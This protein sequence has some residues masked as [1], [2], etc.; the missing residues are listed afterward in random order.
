MQIELGGLATGDAL[1][2]AAAVLDDHGIDRAAIKRQELVDLLER[3]GGHPLSLNLALP[4]LRDHTL[5]E[6]T[7]RFE[8]LLP[9]FTTGAARERNESL[10]VS[11]EFSLRRLGDET[12][13][14]LPDLAV[15]Q[16]GCMEGQMLIVTEMPPA[17]WQE[18]KVELI[19][20]GLM[21]ADET[22]GLTTRLPDDTRYISHFVHFHPTLAPYLASKLDDER[23]Q[24][25]ESRYW[26]TYYRLANDLYSLNIQHP[27]EARAIA[28]RE[29]PNLRRALDLALAAG[30][31]EAAVDFAGR[32]AKFLDNFGRWRER[33][34]LLE[35]I[36]GLQLGST[37]GLT[38]AEYLRLSQRGEALWQQGRA[39]EAEQLF[40]DLLARLEAGAAYDAAY[41]HAITLFWLGSCLASHGRPVQAIEWHRRALGEFERL[42]TSDTSAKGMLGKVY[43]GLGN[44]L[45]KLGRFD[46]AKKA[47]EDGLQISK[48]VGDHRS[49]AVKLGQLGQL[50]RERGNLAAAKRRH[51]EALDTFRALGEPQTEA[52][53]LHHLGSVAL[54]TQDW[55]EAERYY[56]DA[57]RIYEQIRDLPALAMAFNQLAM[58]AEGA[59]RLD[60]AERWYLRA[61]ELGEQLG[62]RSGLAKRLNNLAN[63]YLSQGRL[64]AAER[65]ARRALEIKETLDLSAAPWTTYGILARIAA[66]QGHAEEAAQWRR[67]EQD[68]YAAYAGSA[69]EIQKYQKLIAAV[70][71]AAQGNAEALV[72]MDGEYPRCRLAAKS[73]NVLPM[74]F[75]VSSLASAILR[76]CAWV[77]TGRIT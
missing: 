26:S 24:K 37:A 4:H 66:A 5:A 38:Q 31:A 61:I 48:E 6:L 54:A 20:A 7:A 50:E 27:H 1:E 22:V 17:V 23:R 77:W 67:K 28:V 69:Y 39:A 70:V 3:L 13:A 30:A 47:Y 2:L 51:I 16:G 56:R 63:L 53:T 9:G 74:Q 8:E 10:A 43:T 72:F 59:G 60:E 52:F 46:E 44:N 76:R 11:L 15:F 25:L 19:Q 34:A 75:S 62:D 18:I 57:V 35:Q 14:A 21:T 71:R 32:I 49:A 64:D 33:D 55:D 12:R 73:G 68:S 42:S 29:L 36:A 45:R 40:R 41:D 65:Y 58:V